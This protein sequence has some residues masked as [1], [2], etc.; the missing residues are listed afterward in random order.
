MVKSTR[1][2]KEAKERR[3]NP[4]WGCLF[5]CTYCYPSFRRQAKRQKKRCPRCADYV[6]HAHLE[7]LR[8]GPPKT[9]EGEFVFLC[10]MGDV[11]FAPPEVMMAIIGYCYNWFGTTFL[12]Q[13]KNPR[14]F[15]RYRFPKN[16]ILGTTIETNRDELAKTIS[17]APPPSRRYKNM[18]KLNHPRKLVTIEPIL[19]F[20]LETSVSWIKKIDPEV[21][22][23]GYDSHW[24]NNRLPEP[25]LEKTL[26]LIDLLRLYNVTVRPKLMR[27]AWWEKGH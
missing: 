20:N 17:K 27:K 11:S 16:V 7:R 9:G 13:S 22:Y 19:D 25:P 8:R 14:C 12:L 6:P 24:K 3:I 2:Y 26:K 18:I 15:H 10:D 1:M 4:F 21:V 5:N 23:V